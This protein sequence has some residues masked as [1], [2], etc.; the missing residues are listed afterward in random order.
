[1]PR[2]HEMPTHLNVE[3]TLLGP[4]TPRQLVRLA[5]GLSLAYITWDQLT[6]LPDPL[7]AGLAGL[8]VLVG[9]LVACWRPG[10]VGLDAW[11]LAALAFGL[12]P[13]RLAWARPEP[14]PAEWRQAAEPDWTDLEVELGW[15][16]H[17]AD[18]LHAAAAIWHIETRA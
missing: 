11:A 13:R 3:D 8:L 5:A 2:I 14:A 6:V 16:R 10:G 12:A 9:L 15:H 17:E 18:A 4:L 7:R 1:M